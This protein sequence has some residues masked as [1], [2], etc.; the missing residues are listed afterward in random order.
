[1]TI[2]IADPG[3]CA[4]FAA[5]LSR[6]AAALAE[7]FWPGPLTLVVPD[8]KGGQVGLRCPDCEATRTMLHEA[9]VPVVAPSANLSGEPPAKCAEDVLSAF[10]GRIAAVLDG[11]T[12][13]LGA[14]STVVSVAGDAVT[15]LRAGALA[16]GE[17]RCTVR[18]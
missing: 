8:G 18:S 1:M 9:G 15:I 2:L 13:R 6:A 17:I 7:A 12:A 5:P 11:G 16:E 3:R 14:P 10:D 4:C